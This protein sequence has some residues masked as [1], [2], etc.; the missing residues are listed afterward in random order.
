MHNFLLLS[1]H[2]PGPIRSLGPRQS[3]PLVSRAPVSFPLPGASMLSSLKYK[4]MTRGGV[5]SDTSE[6]MSVS[7]AR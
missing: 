2:D 1:F 3:L 7:P 5:A 4:L 6:N